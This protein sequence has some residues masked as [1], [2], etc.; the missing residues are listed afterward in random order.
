MNADRGTKYQMTMINREQLVVEGVE[1]VASF[2]EEEIVLDTKMGQLLLKGQNLHITQ[3]NL[4]E[5]RLEVAG[6]IKSVDYDEEK[7]GRSR[8][9]SKGLLDRILK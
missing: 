8:G 3:L 1:H 6:L 7:A 4:D 2:D 5:G 9:W